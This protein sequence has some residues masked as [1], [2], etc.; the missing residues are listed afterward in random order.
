[1]CLPVL[2]RCELAALRVHVARRLA[3]R[4]H[5][6]SV[7]GLAQG[8]LGSGRARD[9][10]RVRLPGVATSPRCC[11][12]E[13]CPMSRPI[14][15]WLK[16]NGRILAW[17]EDGGAY[18]TCGWRQRHT[19]PKSSLALSLSLSLFPSLLYSPIRSCYGNNS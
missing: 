6:S 8:W 14:V 5:L 1:M 17:F 15:A 13:C 4:E 11:V 7:G 19:A 10:V 18:S 16:D 3:R 9:R 2:V 12:T